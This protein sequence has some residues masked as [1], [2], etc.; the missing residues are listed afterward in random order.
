M[1]FNSPEFGVTEWPEL[2]ARAMSKMDEDQRIQRR[3]C[4]ADLIEIYRTMRVNADLEI[5]LLIR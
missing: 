5:H 3:G 2:D 1:P 4:R